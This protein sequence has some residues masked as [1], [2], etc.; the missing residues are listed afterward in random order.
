M[1]A[2]KRF[3]QLKPDWLFKGLYLFW[4]NK[5]AFPIFRIFVILPE[6]K[7]IKK[8]TKKEWE[9]LD[10]AIVNGSNA[11]ITKAGI[12]L[13]QALSKYHPQSSNHSNV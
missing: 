1:V 5:I 8:D 3:V 13:N 4:L 2:D 9:E 12:K 6:H 7:R 11:E 10:K